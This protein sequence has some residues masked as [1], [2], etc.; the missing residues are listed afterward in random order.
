MKRIYTLFILSVLLF[1]AGN[2][3]AQKRMGGNDEGKPKKTVKKKKK[4]VPKSKGRQNERHRRRET[5]EPRFT[6]ALKAGGNFQYMQD[7]HENFDNW[8]KPGYMGG[9]Y[10]NYEKKMFGIQVEGI[11]KT[12][13]YYMK[14]DG[15]VHLRTTQVDLPI[16]LSFRPLGWAPIFDRIKIV[17]GPQLQFMVKAEKANREKIKND[18]TVADVAAAMG[19]E[20]D[21]PF[22][23][24][25]G[26]RGLYGLTNINNTKP[27]KQWYN[28][29]IQATVGFRFLN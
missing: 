22:N 19:I 1:A 18:F 5:N 25:V 20:V 17:A 24:H 4:I 11:G 10:V 14:K 7:D 15:A 16:L 29:S 23:L 8:I 27:S 3:Y 12:C 26:V 13:R 9:M 21:L 28:H 6:M 2:T